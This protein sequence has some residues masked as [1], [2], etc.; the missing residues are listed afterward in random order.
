MKF[1]IL[2]I[3]LIFSRLICI[4]QTDSNSN[5]LDTIPNW[6]IN[7][8]YITID[9]LCIL[10]QRIDIN[11]HSFNYLKKY[12]LTKG[13]NEWGN[14]NS[15]ILIE[16]GN[17]NSKN[18]PDVYWLYKLRDDW[19]PVNGNVSNGHK[20]GEWTYNCAYICKIKYRWNWNWCK[21]IIAKKK[22]IYD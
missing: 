9:T 22:I 16:Y 14:V 18:N 2:I 21:T 19:F 20:I 17:V 13:Y 1:I 12:S 10:K 15:N 7:K 8:T 4:G 5:N 6:D 3:I 11:G